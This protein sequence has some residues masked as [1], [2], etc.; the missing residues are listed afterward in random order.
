M[1][2][3]T[4]LSRRDISQKS[5]IPTYRPINLRRLTIKHD[6]C[7]SQLNP[8]TTATLGAEFLRIT[9]SQELFLLWIVEKKKKK[10]KRKEREKEG[11]RK[12]LKA[13][14]K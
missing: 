6:W 14:K 12:S 5:F 4:F 11:K 1:Y 3:M 13:L 2:E 9:F 8:S 10:K 7:W